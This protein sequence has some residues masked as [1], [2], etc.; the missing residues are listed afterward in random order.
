MNLAEANNYAK[1]MLSNHWVKWIRGGSAPANTATEKKTNVINSSL[2][3]KH[4]A[5]CLNMNGVV[6]SRRRVPGYVFTTI[7]IAIMKTSGYRILKQYALFKN[8]RITYSMKEM[9]KG[10]RQCLNH[11]GIQ[12]LIH[13]A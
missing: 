12:S 7:V 10:K 8:S 3:P 11:G 5:S 2:N 6:S 9:T 1:K 13:I 4:C